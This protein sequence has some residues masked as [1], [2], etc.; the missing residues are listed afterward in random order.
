MLIQSFVTKPDNHWT[1][2][3]PF[4]YIHTDSRNVN[5]FFFLNFQN[6]NIFQRNYEKLTFQQK[7]R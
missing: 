7:H 5:F 4:K 6:E 2:V 1:R 3:A